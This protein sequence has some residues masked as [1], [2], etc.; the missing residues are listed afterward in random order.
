MSD[1]K[2]WRVKSS[3]AEQGAPADEESTARGPNY[4]ETKRRKLLEKSFLL[5]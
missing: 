3:Q 1:A 4:A 2:P 5:P